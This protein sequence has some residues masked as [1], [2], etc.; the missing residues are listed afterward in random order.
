MSLHDAVLAVI[1]A[2]DACQI[3]YMLVGSFSTNAYGIERSTKDVD[4]VIA[5][6]DASILQ[7]AHHLPPEFKINPQSRFETVTLSRRYVAAIEGTPFQVRFFLLGDDPHDQDRFR[8]RLK[9][10]YR[11]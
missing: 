5:L 8:R 1:A 4:I 10:T 7:I 2:L 11:G 3:P 6:G 9:A